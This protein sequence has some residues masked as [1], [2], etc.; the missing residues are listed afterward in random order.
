LLDATQA[1]I[2][3]LGAVTDPAALSELARARPTTLFVLPVTP[4]AEPTPHVAALTAA[5]LRAWT[6]CP[7]RHAFVPWS[8]GAIDGHALV[9]CLDDTQRARLE[10]AAPVRDA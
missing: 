1:T 9:F 5:G 7:A 10:R 8:A 3:K 2:V 6:Y 4:D